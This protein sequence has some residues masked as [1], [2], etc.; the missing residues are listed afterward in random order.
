VGKHNLTKRGKLERVS[1]FFF[2]FYRTLLVLNINT[3]RE[4]DRVFEQLLLPENAKSELL[5]RQIFVAAAGPEWDEDIPSFD[6]LSYALPDAASNVENGVGY[7]IG[8]VSKSIP[9]KNCFDEEGDVVSCPA[10]Q[11]IFLGSQNVQD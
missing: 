11:P 9:Y 4:R 8:I 7:V 1:L 10:E 3:I 5:G 6:D 2:I